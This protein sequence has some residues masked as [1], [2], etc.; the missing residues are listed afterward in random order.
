M[1]GVLFSPNR[2]PRAARLTLNYDDAAGQTNE[3]SVP[4]D[5]IMVLYG[6]LQQLIQQGRLHGLAQFAVNTAQ[7]MAVTFGQNAAIPSTSSSKPASLP[8]RSFSFSRDPMLH[9]FY[10]SALENRLV[11]V[12]GDSSSEPSVAVPSVGEWL[13]ETLEL[14][15]KTEHP[16][17]YYD[18]WDELLIE[19]GR[20]VANDRLHDMLRA[21]IAV[22]KAT[23]LHHFL[24]SIP[25]S[26]FVDLTLDRGFT[27][28]LHAAGRQPLSHD[29]LGMIGNW[30]QG[31]AK[32]PNVFHGFVDACTLNGFWMPKRILTNPQQTIA[33]E[34]LREMLLYKDVLLAGVNSYEAEFVFG[35]STFTTL[36]GKFVNTLPAQ[37]HPE[38]WAARGTYI[39]PLST[40]EFIDALRPTAG[41][42]Y[43]PL[44]V[45][46]PVGKLIDL[47]RKKPHDV[48][49]S[50]SRKDKSFV[51]WLTFKLRSAEIS[52]WRD[53]GE[54]EVGA[55]IGKKINEAIGLA[56]CFIVVLSVDSVRSTWVQREIEEALRLEAI[57]E[58]VIMPII[59][60]DLR[61]EVVEP[62][63]LLQ[64][65]YADFRPED[66]REEPVGRVVDAVRKAI[67]RAY[68][69][70]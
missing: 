16:W 10:E 54:I 27:K 13:N 21:R 69:K 42:D 58:V 30:R 64:K 33:R 15:V 36:G 19:A 24:A 5:Q 25:I 50:Y 29:G 40:A 28:A 63:T 9:R 59:V 47:A 53:T 57:G 52:Y 1:G 49:I 68:G 41:D 38:Y 14:G 20:R 35:L 46:S 67:A 18:R 12:I 17:D 70:I 8:P 31:E 65:H 32:Q 37:L 60:G 2:N 45:L 51:D 22:A 7:E 34:G 55:D 11:I 4:L 61:D 26:N 48:F 66:Q 39:S 62:A 56:H 43:G 3:L 6:Y 44:D 23:E